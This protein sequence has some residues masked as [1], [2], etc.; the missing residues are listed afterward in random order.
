MSDLTSLFTFMHWRR[1][2]QPTPVFL[3][4]ESQGWGAWL[5]AVYG[6]T[7]SWTRL[8]RLSSSSAPFPQV[9]M[10]PRKPALCTGGNA[11]SSGLCPGVEG[12]AQ[13]L[14]LALSRLH[15]LCVGLSGRVRG[16]E[17]SLSLF[18]MGV[19]TGHGQSHLS[20]QRA[21]AA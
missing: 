8:K 20:K 17:S 14:C 4:G 21:K 2:W 6:V 3:P 7:Q 9:L 1:K 15:Q 10:W 12:P 11:D 18:A 19:G 16:P 5:A 13:T